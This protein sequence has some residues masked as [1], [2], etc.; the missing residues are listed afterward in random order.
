MKISDKLTP[1]SVE[2]FEDKGRFPVEEFILAQPIKMQ[3]KIFRTIDLLAKYGTFLREPYSKYLDDNIFELRIQQGSDI[4]RILYFFVIGEKAI[5][6][7]AF[8]KKSQK[9][10][11]AELLL[12]KQRREKYLQG[13]ENF[14]EQKL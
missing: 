7:N 5:L 6:T 2:Y 13:R 10:P 3:A 1:I 11:P 8:I 14:H 9:P 4:S 12:A